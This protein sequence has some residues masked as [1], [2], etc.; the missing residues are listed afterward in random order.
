MIIF[1]TPRSPVAQPRSLICG[2]FIGALC[3]CIVRLAVDPY[4]HSM[5]CALAVSISVFIMQLTETLHPP[6]GATALL[7]VTIQPSFPWA[8]FL[9][10]FVPALTGAFIMLIVA[11]IIN[12]IPKTRTYPSFW[13]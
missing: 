3:G 13:W 10:I 7:A 9:F 8:H 11:L 12:N 2:H 5:G 4:E 6:G 1:C